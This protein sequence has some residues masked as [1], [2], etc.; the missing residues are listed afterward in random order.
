MYLA[1]RFFCPY[2]YTAP[3][4]SLPGNVACK[5]HPSGKTQSHVVAST[6]VTLGATS[7]T[8]CLR[9]LRYR[10]PAEVDVACASR[11]WTLACIE[12]QHSLHAGPCAY[13]GRGHGLP[14]EQG[15]ILCN[16]DKKMTVM[17]MHFV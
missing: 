8:E 10:V 15:S 17:I 14:H 1:P 5:G 12:A 11:L 6:L 13:N 3:R 9:H 4:V 16:Y 7:G 2:M